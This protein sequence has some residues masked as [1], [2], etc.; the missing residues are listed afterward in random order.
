MAHL[1]KCGV[2]HLDLAA[3]N[4]LLTHPEELAKI[5]DFGLSRMMRGSGGNGQEEDAAQERDS[6]YVGCVVCHLSCI[7]HVSCVKCH[8]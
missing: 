1:N 2:V 5:S 3:R 7:C 6:Q 4:I 8:A